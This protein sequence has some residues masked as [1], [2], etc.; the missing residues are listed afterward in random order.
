MNDTL[1]KIEA[2]KELLRRWKEQHE[3][4]VRKSVI[5]NG[6]LLCTCG[7]SQEVDGSEAAYKAQ[8][9]HL[10]ATKPQLELPGIRIGHWQFW[11]S[12]TKSKK[13]QTWVLQCILCDFQTKC[14]D[15]AGNIRPLTGAMSRRRKRH[16]ANL[17]PDTL[18]EQEAAE[19]AVVS[20]TDSVC[21]GSAR[22]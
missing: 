20:I 18:S 15:F 14:V 5:R 13:H 21:E 7:F 12:L 19:N 4:W 17:H 1:T 22:K 8:A 10:K 16:D 9:A 2:S 11:Q 3:C 6:R